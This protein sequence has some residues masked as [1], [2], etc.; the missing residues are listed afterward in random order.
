MK[1]QRGFTLVELLISIT[2]VAALSTG[3]L[4][5][6]RT[7]LLTLDKVQNRLDDN[8]RVMSIQQMMIRQISSVMPVSGDCGSARSVLFSGT[9]Q[10]LRMVSSYSL[11]EGAR[12][13]P[14]Y[15]E[16]QVLPD[17]EGGFR[18]VENEFVFFSPASVGP[19]C[20]APFTVTPQTFEVARGLASV[21]FQYREFTPDSPATAKWLGVWDRPY[22]PAA[23]KIDIVPLRA[24][25]NRLAIRGV[26][27]PIR[28]TREVLAQ[29][30][31]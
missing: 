10:S 20:A 7:G 21:V 28:I 13:Y 2:L 5:A 6:M 27:V 14:Q 16:Y 17:P 24:E 9:P 8:R 26:S 22:L 3:M 25:P 15:V 29:Y 1:S 19:V 11:A 4:L 30:D 12:G 31:D 18:L 23:V